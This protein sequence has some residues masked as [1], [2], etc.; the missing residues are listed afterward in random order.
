MLLRSLILCV[1]VAGVGLAAYAEAVGG[2]D[3]LWVAPGAS[4]SVPEAEITVEAEDAYST[5]S[6]IVFTGE[7]TAR[8]IYETGQVRFELLDDSGQTLEEGLLWLELRRGRSPFRFRWDA[9]DLPEGV[10]TARL[11]YLLYPG[12][13][14]GWKELTVYRYS[15][16]GLAAAAKEAAADVDALVERLR[17]R[18]DSAPYARMRA[19]L[20][21]DAV[22]RAAQRIEAGDI[23]HAAYLVDYAR[24]TV[25]STRSLLVFARNTP[26]Y[27]ESPPSVTDAP[28]RSRNG[29][30]YAGDRPVFLAGVSG[31]SDLAG[32]LPL[33][34]RYGLNYAILSLKPDEGSPGD[35]ATAIQTLA[36]KGHDAGMQ[37]SLRLPPFDDSAQ[38][39]LASWEEED[40]GEGV[41]AFEFE[42]VRAHLAEW[43]FLG[44]LADKR[45]IHSIVIDA[46]P[47]HAPVS[48]RLRQ[49]FLEYVKS[50][51][52]D[53]HEMNWIWQTRYAGFDEV[54]ID[55]DSHRTVY[56]Y[57]LQGYY[58]Q[59]VYDVLARL[60]PEARRLLDGAPLQL[61]L[62]AD[63]FEEGE[64]RSGID[65]ESLSAL[66][67]AIAV[68]WANSP[69]DPYYAMAF[70]RSAAV[71]TLLRSFAPRQPLVNVAHQFVEPEAPLRNLSIRDYVHTALW[72]AAM[73]GVSGSAA[74][75]WKPEDPATFTG[76]S[77]RDRPDAMEGYATAAL[78]INRLA[79]LVRAFQQDSPEVGI[80]WSMPSKIYGDGDPYLASALEAFEG[81]AFSGYN[82]RFVSEQQCVLGA[83][84]DIAVLVIPHALAVSN[85]AFEAIE[86]YVADGGMLIRTGTLIP[87]DARGRSRTD[88][89]SATR[90]TVVLRGHDKSTNYL[91]AV[92]GA[93]AADHLPPIPRA[94]NRYGYPLEGVRT[95]YVEH[96]GNGYLYIVNLRKEPVVSHLYGARQGGRDLIRGRDMRF[97]ALLEPLDPML[98][99]LDSELRHDPEDSD[100]VAEL[101]EQEPGLVGR[102]IQNGAAAWDETPTAVVR[103][104]SGDD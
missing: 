6:P 88:V 42:A 73:H 39:A 3:R 61:R 4:R 7:V 59:Q 46:I 100:A 58:Q 11:T 53:R 64:A 28:V 25:R 92:D 56:Q 97:P 17:E 57:D 41:G 75:V 89:I 9:R 62:P 23:A 86:E 77:L 5:E 22:Q 95:R 55:W 48:E 27:F 26:E 93:Y 36:D 47:P 21:Q 44:A 13:L 10:Y 51:Y 78:D 29:G 35:R 66:F 31:G 2:H 49:G 82:A 101:W 70:P 76:Y 14:G 50:T 102:P 63:A 24:R 43:S 94:I 20:A 33:L 8:T 38:P 85:D 83:L 99:R 30:F 40:S 79:P 65:R 84:D 18:E 37:V 80:L 81:I 104:R 45:A 1:L 98:I 74:A 60:E 72:E 54:D 19:A 52:E 16:E 15:A 12:G 90:Q 32:D 68:E 67:D 34:A 71:Y 87:Y 96:H 69:R 91:H 103:P